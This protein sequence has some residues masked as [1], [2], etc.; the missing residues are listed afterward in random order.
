MINMKNMKNSEK[1]KNP[2][3]NLYMI[4]DIKAR[5]WFPPFEAFNDDIA[6][7]YVSSMMASADSI[8]GRNP[9]DFELYIIGDFDSA[10]GQIDLLYPFDLICRFVDLVQREEVAHV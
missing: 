5:R 2:C 7:R 8:F 6:R 10:D 4:R 1:Q 3:T 9:E